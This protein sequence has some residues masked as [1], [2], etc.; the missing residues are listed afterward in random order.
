M[1]SFAKISLLAVVSAVL[2]TGASASYAQQYGA[3]APTC[4][5]PALPACAPSCEVP[6]YAPTCDTPTC[7]VATCAPTCDNPMYGS[8]YGCDAACYTGCDLARSVSELAAAPFKWIFCELTSGIYPDC[9][10]A[11]RP[12]KSNCNPCTICGDYVGGCNDSGCYATGG[13]T[14]LQCSPCDQNYSFPSYSSQS[15]YQSAPTSGLNFYDVEAYDASPSKM[16]AKLPTY[17]SRVANAPKNDFTTNVAMSLQ[18][19]FG[20]T[21]PAAQFRPVEETIE[22]SREIVREVEPQ[23]YAANQRRDAPVAQKNVVT[24]T[25]PQTRAPNT[26]RSVSYEQDGVN[27]QRQAIRQTQRVETTNAVQ[28]NA[29]NLREMQSKQ[30]VRIVAPQEQ[31]SVPASKKQFGTIRAIK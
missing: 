15:S 9:G 18:R 27:A 14:S 31:Q 13:Y 4:D 6:T 8:L 25:A 1:K 28:T 2:L 17:N 29:K 21:R 3:C 5:V 11:P 16:S 22:R 19:A 12:P 24:Q 20:T 30:N 26:V 23:Q 10:C 7:D